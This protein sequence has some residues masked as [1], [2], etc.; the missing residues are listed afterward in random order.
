MHE[1]NAL[2]AVSGRNGWEVG[3][4]EQP[5]DF[6]AYHFRLFDEL[7]LTLVVDKQGDPVSGTFSVI[8]GGLTPPTMLGITEGLL[9]RAGIE[10]MA[11][12][13]H[14]GAD[15]RAQMTQALA[16]WLNFRVETY[17]E[18]GDQLLEALFRLDSDQ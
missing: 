6:L 7:V 9:S 1:Y 16:S 8:T 18:D 14:S 3:P 10:G 12:I 17:G 15:T 13:N 2:S 11:L 5:G 4:I